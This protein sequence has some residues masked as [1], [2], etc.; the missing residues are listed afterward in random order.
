MSGAVS[1]SAPNSFSQFQIRPVVAKGDID[2]SLGAVQPRFLF[3]FLSKFWRKN[4][5]CKK[6]Y[7]LQENEWITPGA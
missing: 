3:I 4:N 2:E 6:N 7:N 1:S 5:G